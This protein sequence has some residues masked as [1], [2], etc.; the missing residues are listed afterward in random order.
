MNICNIHMVMESQGTR[1]TTQGE[2]AA[3]EMAR[4]LT[5]Q[6]GREPG[7]ISKGDLARP[8]GR[9]KTRS[10]TIGVPV[11]VKWVKGLTS[12]AGDAVKVQVRSPVG[13]SGLKDLAS[14]AERI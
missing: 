6:P 7:A 11:V 14:G 4:S 3:K 9:R 1:Q 12:G 2:G 13:C 8:D 10:S 5:P